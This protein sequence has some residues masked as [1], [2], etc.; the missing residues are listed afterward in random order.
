M[1]KVLILFFL[2]SQ[3]SSAQ[4]TID[5]GS[6]TIDS[7]AQLIVIG[8]IKSNIDIKG[9]CKIIMNGSDS[10][11]INMGGRSI[12]IL[13][14]NNSQNVYLISDLRIE[15]SLNFILGKLKSSLFNITL[16]SSANCSGASNNRF[17]EFTD[18]GQLFKELDDDIV[19]FEV[20][21]GSSSIYRPVF[22]STN[23]SFYSQA[24]IG[25]KSIAL[26]ETNMP[27][28]SKDYLLTYWP[29]T[30][31]GISGTVFVSGKYDEVKDVNGNKSNLRGYFFDG[32]NWS[33][34]GGVN[35]TISKRVGS[36]VTGNGGNLFGMNKF[37]Y[38]GIRA[39][40]Q[41]AY[42]STNGLMNESLRTILP[43][44]DPYRTVPYNSTF[45]HINNEEVETT[46]GTPF[47]SNQS[48][49]TN[50]VDWV[51]LE[52]RNTNSSPGN[53]I[54]QTRSALI[55]RSG[56]IV[57]IDGLRPVSFFNLPNGNY[58]I[59]VRHRNH[60]SI[61]LN[62]INGFVGLNEKMTTAYTDNLMNLTTVTQDK[63]YGN[64]GSYTTASHPSYKTVNLLWSGNVNGNSNSKYSG[65]SNDRASI[66]SNLGNNELGVLFGYFRSDLNLNGIVK[67]SGSSN[68][69][70]FLL[71][72]VLSNNELLIR[73]EQRPN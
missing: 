73:T 20:P 12:P 65:A 4:L 13:E 57:D 36:F 2:F 48:S 41:G 29:I 10:Q 54:L 15:K 26:P 25:V 19:S 8:N 52:L 64:L 7:A 70:G 67:Y 53:Q 68:D 69:R 34:E 59:T 50:I 16:S 56:F 35:D 40:L 71:S 60:L 30:R 58:S 72:N 11:S 17:V 28:R 33:S 47:I 37:L 49:E 9:V 23:S 1:K 61:S 62:P 21:I 14:I 6:I 63:I 18:K 39:F 66:L 3:K 44:K 38:V 27:L 51:F 43:T 22:I 31:T 55:N 45:M 32:I 42:N 5:G 24:K 46:I